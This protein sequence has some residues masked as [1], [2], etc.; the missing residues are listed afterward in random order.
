M[1]MP[2]H[3]LRNQDPRIADRNRRL[4]KLASDRP[5]PE[6]NTLLRKGIWLRARNQARLR[7]CPTPAVSRSEA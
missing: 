5:L 1:N 2:M 7:L 3:P 6:H 4:R